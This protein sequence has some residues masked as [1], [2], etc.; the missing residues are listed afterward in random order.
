MRFISKAIAADSNWGNDILDR[1]AFSQL[2]YPQYYSNSHGEA[3]YSKTQIT[4]VVK[5]MNSWWSGCAH[6]SYPFELWSWAPLK[7][8]MGRGGELPRGQSETLAHFRL[9][10]F[11][12]L[13]CIVV[14]DSTYTM[15]NSLQDQFASWTK[16]GL[17]RSWIWFSRNY[18]VMTLK[19]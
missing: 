3:S 16:L 19:S 15:I 4:H 18:Y 5:M 14:P 13:E 11:N 9:W 2:S 6:P 1:S 7:S 8:L 12:I 17:Q 10:P